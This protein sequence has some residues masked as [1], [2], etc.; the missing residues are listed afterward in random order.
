M[1]YTIMFEVQRKDGL[2][3]EEFVDLWLRHS[4]VA[5]GLP[6]L[7]HYEILPV[8][9][10]IDA[11]EGAPDGFVMMRFD[12]KADADAAF[13]SPEMKASSADSADFARHFSMFSLDSHRIL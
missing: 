4:S 10:A 7:R 1:S 12:S 2:S 6:R 13:A 5:A 11:A 3:D 9:G 8:T